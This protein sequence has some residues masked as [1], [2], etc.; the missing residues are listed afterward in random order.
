MIAHSV[1]YKPR[2]RM[3]VRALEHAS[4]ARRPPQTG[5]SDATDAALR[6]TYRAGATTAHTQCGPIPTSEPGNAIST[7]T[8]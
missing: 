2:E 5:R 8:G 6:F 1:Q 3:A 7:T 4:T